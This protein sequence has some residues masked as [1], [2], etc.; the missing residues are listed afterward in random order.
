MSP[1]WLPDFLGLERGGE[2]VLL[3]Q[4]ELDI[5]V[6]EAHLRDQITRHGG[7][8]EWSVLETERILLAAARVGQHVF[9]LHVLANCGGRRVSC[10]LRPAA[11]GAKRVLMAGHIKPWRDSTPSERLDPRN[12]LVACPFMTWHSA[13]ACSLSMEGSASASPAPWPRPSGPTRG[14]AV[15]RAATAARGAAPAGGRPASCP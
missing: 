2:L 5:S 14:Q 10:G 12:G 4:E 3:G 8:S 7:A 1:D 13:P 9:A 6:L 11:F 15:L